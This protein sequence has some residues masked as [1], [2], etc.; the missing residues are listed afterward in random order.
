M[1]A[2]RRKDN[3]YFL[4]RTKITAFFEMEHKKAFPRGGEGDDTDS[5]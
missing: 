3:D 5:E 2:L 4:T 1:L